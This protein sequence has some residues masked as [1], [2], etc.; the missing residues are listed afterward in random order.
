MF[1]SLERG[2]DP[3]ARDL[4]GRNSRDVQHQT[5]PR[6]RQRRWGPLLPLLFDL[7]FREWY[8]N[9]RSLRVPLTLDF[10]GTERLR[11]TP[12]WLEPTRTVC[13]F[14]VSYT[15]HHSTSLMGTNQPHGNQTNQPLSHAF[16]VYTSAAGSGSDRRNPEGGAYKNLL[17]PVRAVGRGPICTNPVG[18]HQ[19]GR[20]DL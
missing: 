9:W 18:V 4:L 8:F 16:D 14:L 15:P 6:E 13:G 7:G 5:H 12:N 20:S 2:W 3:E 11:G 17:H 19:F 1:L 10:R